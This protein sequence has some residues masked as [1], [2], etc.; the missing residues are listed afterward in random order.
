MSASAE[1][2]LQE[3]GF[4]VVASLFGTPDP[5]PGKLPDA[6]SRRDNPTSGPSSSRLLT[7]DSPRTKVPN[8][9]HVFG[10]FRL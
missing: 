10:R 7:T 3:R 4:D 2:V 9:D 6:A 1:H 5:Q 8:L